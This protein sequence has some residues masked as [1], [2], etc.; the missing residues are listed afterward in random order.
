MKITF[1]YED[2]E[3]NP[4]RKISYTTREVGLDELLNDYKHFLSSIG[5]ILDNKEIIAENI[6]YDEEK[7]D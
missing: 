1:V 5:F 2:Q 3:Q 6:D 4:T 7:E